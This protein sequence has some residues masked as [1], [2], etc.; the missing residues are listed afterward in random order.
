MSWLFRGGYPPA[1]PLRDPRSLDIWFSGYVQTY[2]ERDLRDIQQISSLPDFRRLMRLA[3]NR[4]GRLF[5]QSEVA[6]DAGLAQ[7]T[8]HRYANLLE[9]SYQIDRLPVY[10]S[11]PNAPLMKSKKLFWKDAGLG[12]WLAGLSDRKALTHRPDI[13]FWLEQAVFQTLQS[14][15]SLAPAHRRLHY[16]RDPKGN[17]VDFVLEQ[18]G[19][20]VALE[21]KSGSQVYPADLT[22]LLAFRK[23]LARKD[24]VIR[25]AVLF[26]GPA[27]RSLGEDLFALPL[28][29]LF[30]A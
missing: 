2:L 15:R 1:I 12:A 16:W 8:A 29:W 5:N 22:G 23:S 28:G 25:S 11:N 21:V 26:D 20:V 27:A 19:A 6:R 3:A 30:P 10:S 7:P 17:E 18:D 9:T 13:G 4:I 14:W 24:D